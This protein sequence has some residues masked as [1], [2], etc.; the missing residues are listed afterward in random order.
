MKT[1]ICLVEFMMSLLASPLLASDSFGG[2][3]V[4]VYQVPD[5]VKIAEVIPGTPAFE[6]NLQVGNVIIAVDGMS[7][8]GKTVE[9][10]IAKLRG[11]ENKPLEITFLNGDDTLSTML[12]RSQITVKDLERDQVEAWYGNKSQLDVQEL[13]TY[14]SAKE[15]NKQL[16]AVLQNGTLV[17]SQ[18]F[19]DAGALN[20]VYVKRVDE[21]APKTKPQKNNKQVSA[22]LKNVNRNA[23]EF[24][25]KSIGSVTISVMD[26][27]GAVVAKLVENNARK[28]FNS[29]RWNSQ[30]VPNGRYMVTV[31][32]DGTVSGKYVILK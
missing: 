25:L 8:K 14:A 21:F 12:R 11:L 9:E 7:L 18:M 31:E 17:K 26:A 19:V 5:G 16:V 15:N 30:S 27:D 13:E 2:I 20:A 28:G 23:V 22:V 32:H 24:E 1:R 10:S 29:L 4:A 3:G 6:S